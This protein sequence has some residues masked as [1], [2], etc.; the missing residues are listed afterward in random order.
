MSMLA[1]FCLLLLVLS[2]LAGN[3]KTVVLP[4]LPGLFLYPF[5][6]CF[7]GLV[8][9][10]VLAVN[11][12]ISTS[13]NLVELSRFCCVLCQEKKKA[14]ERRG[15]PSLVASLRPMSYVGG[16]EDVNMMCLRYT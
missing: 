8:F 3:A 12:D 5:S 9:F 2:A 16:N 15:A 10:R 7:C 4:R 6:F 11:V 14:Q 13:M 1:K